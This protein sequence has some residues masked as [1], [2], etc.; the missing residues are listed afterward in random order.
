MSAYNAVDGVTMTENDLLEDPAQLRVGLRRRRDLATGP[1]CAAS[2]PIPAAQDLAMPGPA[3]G[4]GRPRRRGP[5]RPRATRRT[6]TARCC[7]CCCSP[8]ASEP[9]TDRP[10]STPGRDR[11]RAPSRMRPP[12]RAPCCCSNDGILPLAAGL[13]R[14]ASPSSATTPAKPAPRAA[15]A[16]PCCPS[17]SSRR[18][19]RSAH[20]LPGARVSYELGA[21]VQDGVAEIPL[22]HMTNPRTG[23]PGVTV[24]VRGR[25]RRPSCSA[26]TAARP[27]S[28]GSA[29]T[30]RSRRRRQ[31]RPAHHV[32]ARRDRPDPA[33]LR[34]REPRSRCSWTVSSCVDDQPVIE[35]TDLGAAF[36]EPAVAHRR[37]RCRRGGEPIDIRA[38]FDAR[39]RRLAAGRRAQRD[40]RHRA[41]RLRPGRSDRQR[42]RSRTRRRTSPSSWSARTPRSS[43]RATTA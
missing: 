43:P 30:P 10:P 18:S 19:T 8:S 32:H 39:R 35:G 14:E 9:S 28:S 15:A 27:P 20:A 5:R 41:R 40:A 11:R 36:L 23:E 7:G 21:V 29:A 34:R 4:V 25:R 42:G 22:E 37:H 17:T 31:R 24:D 33:R 16:P 2:A 12:S 38:E 3:P 13:G 6:S 1:L 26:R